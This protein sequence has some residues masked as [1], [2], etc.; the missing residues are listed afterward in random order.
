M[1]ETVLAERTLG[2]LVAE[3]PGRGALFDHL[4]LD[5]CCHGQRT[6]AE[7]CRDAGLD[8][9]PVLAALEAERREAPVEGSRPSDADADADADAGALADRIVA[10]HHRYLRDEL[11]ALVELAAKVAEAHRA[12]H[13][14]LDAVRDHVAAL[15]SDLEPHM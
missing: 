14:E 13:P 6:L 15:R 1:T 3:A 11:P 9:A 5:Y 7:A 2:D 4:A 10:G 12:R 8:V